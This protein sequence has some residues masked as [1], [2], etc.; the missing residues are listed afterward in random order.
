MA[1]VYDPQLAA[2]GSRIV[3]RRM[4]LGMSGSEL[5]IQADLTPSSLSLYE[6]GQ[7]A[8]GVDK[9]HR[10]ALALRVPLSY[11]QTD[12]LDAFSEMPRD[13][14]PLIEKLKVLPVDQQQ[15]M[16][17]MISAQLSVL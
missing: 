14:Y 2:I 16:I 11:L 7:R 13:F 1:N 3:K 12:E 5:A 15:M 10:I 17:R 6:S 8:M 4:E 9:L